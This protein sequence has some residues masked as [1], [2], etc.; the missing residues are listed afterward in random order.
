MRSWICA[1][2]RSRSPSPSTSPPPMDPLERARVTVAKIG[3]VVTSGALGNDFY[4]A[5]H[6]GTDQ[7]SQY[8]KMKT[9]ERKAYMAQWAKGFYAP[10]L[11]KH[12][13]HE[14]SSE[15]D[16]TQS[17]MVNFGALVIAYGGWSWPPAVGG[18]KQTF[19]RYCQTGN[20]WA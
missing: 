14:A 11:L 19:I 4:M 13:S 16:E 2:L 3:T 10:T 9:A 8:I 18:A 1:K 12:Q 5:H 7:R 6:E 17:E 15:A 20:T